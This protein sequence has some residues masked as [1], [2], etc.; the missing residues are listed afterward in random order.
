MQFLNTNKEISALEAGKLDPTQSN[1]DLL[2]IGSS[3]NLLVYDVL[4]NADVFEK[5]INEGLSSIGICCEK[6]LPDVG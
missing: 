3:T 1:L 6:Y 2:M 4:N 5:E